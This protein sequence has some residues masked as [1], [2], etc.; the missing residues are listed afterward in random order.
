MLYTE[1][2][3]EICKKYVNTLF[4]TIYKWVLKDG[5]EQYAHFYCYM[6]KWK[7]KERNELDARCKYKPYLIKIHKESKKIFRM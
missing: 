5:T 3:C 6:K 7:N 4:T 2:K 1:F